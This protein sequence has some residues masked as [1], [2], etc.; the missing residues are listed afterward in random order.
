MLRDDSESFTCPRTVALNPI[1][2]VKIKGRTRRNIQCRA[3]LFDPIAMTRRR[4][5]LSCA[6]LG[7][8]DTF[9]KICASAETRRDEDMKGDSIAQDDGRDYQH[10]CNQY[11]RGQPRAPP[12][13]RAHE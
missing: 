5:K 4:A 10:R 3:L 12:P 11:T 1:R 7:L 13:T 2:I 8:A 6:P 9:Q